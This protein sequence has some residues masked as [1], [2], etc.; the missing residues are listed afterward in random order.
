MV[1]KKITRRVRPVL[2]GTLVLAFV[3]IGASRSTSPQPTPLTGDQTSRTV[4]RFADQNAKDTYIKRAGLTPEQLQSTTT[5]G[6]YVVD[7]PTT[8]LPSAKN[9]RTSPIVKYHALQ[10]PNDPNYA[11]QPG[12]RRVS[13]PA[14]WDISTGASQIIIAVIDTGFALNHEDLSG[15]WALNSGEMGVTGQE[16]AAPNC[17]S[18]GLALDKSCNNFDDDHDGFNDNWR[19]WDFVDNTEI[20]QAGKSSSFGAYVGHGTSTAS[21]AAATGN[22]SKG[23]AGMCWRCRILPIEVLDDTGSGDTLSVSDGIYYAADHGA[24]VINLSLG[25]NASDPVMLD[26]INYALS[27][28]IVVVAAS[29]NSG[30]GNMLYPALYPG[31]ISVGATDNSDTV[32]SFSSTGP[33]LTLTAPGISIYCATWSSANATSGY[34][35][36]SGTSLAAPMVAGAAGLVRSAFPA[37]SR[38]TIYNYLVGN[39]DAVAGMGGQARTDQYGY[40]R[41]N[42]YHAM[43]SFGS[44]YAGQS[45]YPRMVAGSTATAYLKYRNTGTGTWYDDTG[46]PSAPTG[47]KPVHL[48]TSHGVNRASSLGASWGS[49]SNRPATNFLAVYAA[50]GT[51]LATDQHAVAAGQIG[52]FGVVFNAPTSSSGTYHEFFQPI[53]EGGTTM[54]DPWT[55]LD[56]TVDPVS[57]LSQYKSQGAY[58]TIMS[59]STTAPSWIEYSN[60]GNAPWYDDSGLASAPSGSRPVH[61]ATS[62]AINRASAIGNSWGGDR[63]RATGAFAVVYHADGTAYATNPHV[64]APGESAR[65]AFSIGADYGVGP[66]V[67]REFFQPIVEGVTT[68][69]DP[70]TFLDATVTRGV[71]ASQYVSQSAYPLLT[72]SAPSATVQISYRNMG[73]L[74]WYDDATA[75]ANGTH[76]VH[77]A[78]SHAINRTSTLGSG[79]GGDNNRASGS[80]MTVYHADG[81]A[82][83]TNPHIVAPGV[84]RE[85]FQPIVEGVTTMN[86]PWTFLDV[87]NQ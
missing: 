48:A 5:Q 46:L 6:Q 58:P 15:R 34:S 77:L 13:A 3:T 75:I 81:T 22:N 30:P 76:P 38:Q 79:W 1:A 53:V 63:N 87:T 14:A 62:H 23:I 61:L 72:S 86:D 52:A 7:T 24:Q 25:A 29:G 41:L 65:F 36:A 51:T 42:V 45:A 50:D 27:K 26:A 85:F 43:Q 19:G 9:V 49:G 2:L 55:F 44:Q 59:G 12:L 8:Q 66:G 21:T 64:A 20:P 57:Y 31:V 78:T 83:V 54:N 74:S 32:A 28:D 18:R 60:V 71:F 17:T 16:G 69:N 56:V 37:A 47:T 68:M 80:F 39:L 73:N 11:S 35:F 84:Y 40:G 67:Y 33:Q 70:W 82:Y 4:L 10:T